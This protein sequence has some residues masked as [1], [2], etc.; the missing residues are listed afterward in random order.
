MRILLAFIIMFIPI[1]GKLCFGIIQQ[2]D[3]LFDKFISYNKIDYLKNDK[4]CFGYFGN[5]GGPGNPR[6][7]AVC[8]ANGKDFFLKFIVYNYKSN[9][10]ETQKSLPISA[11]LAEGLLSVLE[12]KIGR[13]SAG[14]S[15]RGLD[16]VN[17]EFGI[18]NGDLFKVAGV[19]SPDRN[20]VV[21][22][23]GV[24]SS[25]KDEKEVARIFEEINS[26]L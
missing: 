8:S 1:H 3:T 2:R 14:T 7:V 18:R 24:I 15:H 23:M 21:G 12:K 10:L 5:A 19:W 9:T 26:M 13:K 20:S 22:K 25:A 16:G 6:Y 17:Y 11:G 4:T